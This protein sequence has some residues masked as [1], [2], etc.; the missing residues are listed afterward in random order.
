MGLSLQR[1][2]R[3]QR[4]VGAE[5]CQ[6]FGVAG[7]PNSGGFGYG[8]VGFGEPQRLESSRKAAPASTMMA[9]A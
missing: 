3:P 4:S 7:V 9:I 1:M 8:R 2:R 6:I 5:V